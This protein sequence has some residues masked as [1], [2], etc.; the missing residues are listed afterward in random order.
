MDEVEVRLREAQEALSNF[1]SLVE[2]VGWQKMKQIAD[3][4]LK[5]RMPSAIGKM[6]SLLEVPKKEF[7]KGEIAGID[8]F[9]RL[10]EIAIEGLI[11]DINELEEKLGYVEGE[12]T[13]GGRES[14]R[15]GTRSG[16]GVG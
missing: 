1:R 4:Q 7:E 14:R 10:P 15:A 2:S 13:A 16:R 12:R 3:G 5:L 11:N 9:M 6:E 8:L